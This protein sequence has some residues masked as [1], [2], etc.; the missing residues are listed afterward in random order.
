M[1]SWELSDS[2]N[3]TLVRRWRV[4]PTDLCWYKVL[5]ARRPVGRSHLATVQDK[6]ACI[7]LAAA[8]FLDLRKSQ[9]EVFTARGE[10]LALTPPCSRCAGQP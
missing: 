5:A 9:I 8:F 2:S 4:P 7:L 1:K 10:R 6:E 3:R